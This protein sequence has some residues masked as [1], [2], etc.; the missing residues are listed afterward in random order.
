MRVYGLRLVELRCCVML[1][2]YEDLCLFQSVVDCP[3]RVG[4]YCTVRGQ[5]PNKL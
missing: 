5:G 4:V 3:R 2:T 1:L